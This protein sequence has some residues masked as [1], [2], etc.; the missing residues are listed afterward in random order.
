MLQGYYLTGYRQELDIFVWLACK[1]WYISVLKMYGTTHLFCDKF[2][3]S[4]NSTGQKE[5]GKY[6]KERVLELFF[7]YKY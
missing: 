2:P 5:L 3:N 4:L 1:R 6:I 7:S